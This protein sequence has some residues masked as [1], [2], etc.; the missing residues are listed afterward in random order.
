MQPPITLSARNQIIFCDPASHCYRQPVGRWPSQ[1]VKDETGSG[2]L[3]RVSMLSR[4][5]FRLQLNEKQKRWEPNG[6]SRSPLSWSDVHNWN[7][8]EADFDVVVE[9]FTQFS[10]PAERALK[11]SG[12]KRSLKSGGLLIIQ[13]YTP[14]QLEYGTGGPKQIEIFIR[15]QSSNEPFPNF[16]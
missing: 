9:I 15:G 14:K 2:W 6:T 13:G 7:Y 11:W 1:M 5:I 16:V 4:S 3:N 12:M 8:P 10:S